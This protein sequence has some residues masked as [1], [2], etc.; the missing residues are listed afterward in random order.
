MSN[1]KIYTSV[2]T[3]KN[4]FE[5]GF[6]IADPTT[7][8]LV[9]ISYFIIERGLTIYDFCEFLRGKFN[10]LTSFSDKVAFL[11][12]LSLGAFSDDEIY[13]SFYLPPTSECMSEYKKIEKKFKK[14][15][16]ISFK[17]L[18]GNDCEITVDFFSAKPIL[19]RYWDAEGWLHIERY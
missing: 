14:H 6:E 12:V 9:K 2:K 17:F 13:H 19:C 8:E 1:Q 16:C 18:L 7:G 5:K 4:L 3:M 10:R 15:E 11:T